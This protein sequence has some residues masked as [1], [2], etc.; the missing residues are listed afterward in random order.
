MAVRVKS[1]VAQDAI[2]F[3]RGRGH[4]DEERMIK[5]HDGYVEIPVTKA[6]SERGWELVQQPE[7]IP[8]APRLS[9]ELIKKSLGLEGEVAR[10]LRHWRLLGEVLVISLPEG[11]RNKEEIARGLLRLI[12]RAKS[13]INCQGISGVHREPE[14]ELIAGD[15][16][17]TIH[18]ENDCLYKLD[19]LRVMFS[20]GN[21][22]ERRRMATISN[23]NETVLD[24]FAGV[25]QFTI[26]L[27]KYSSPRRVIAI[28]KNPTAYSYLTENIKL[29][30][31]GNVEAIKGDCRDVSPRGVAD[32]VIM[33]YF[34]SEDFLP[35]ALDALRGSGVIHHHTLVNKHR[36]PERA[37]GLAA[38]IEERGYSVKVIG[39]KKVKS[40]A[41]SLHHYVIDLSV[42]ATK[43]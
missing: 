5:Q 13:V 33:G 6:P 20:S 28:E 14:A 16:S 12:P 41:P 18:R 11:T 22:G 8:R 38:S 43:I 15:S 36:L 3:L 4:L 30:Q 23:P 21:Q 39:L 17:V 24:M 2:K 9:H 1:S 27:A 42:S 29:N 7:P 26:P 25:G 19:P 37:E 32:R 40:Y 34:N 35:T 31:L 10:A